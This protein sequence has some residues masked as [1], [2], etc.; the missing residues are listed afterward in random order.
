MPLSTQIRLD[1]CSPRYGALQGSGKS[2]P[3]LFCAKK[4]HHASLRFLMDKFEQRVICKLWV[5]ENTPSI[6]LSHLAFCREDAATELWT[7]RDLKQ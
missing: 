5:S 1:A 2:H 4:A 6:L 7:R 3:F